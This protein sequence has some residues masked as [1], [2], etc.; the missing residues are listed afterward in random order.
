MV[1]KAR[2]FTFCSNGFL[3]FAGIFAEP[4]SWKGKAGCV[5][6]RSPSNYNANMI[7]IFIDPNP[8]RPAVPASSSLKP[9]VV[10][11]N[12]WCDFAREC[13]WEPALLM[14]LQAENHAAFMWPTINAIAAESLPGDR[15]ALR[16]A[17]KQVLAALGRLI[18]ARRI[19]R[20]RRDGVIRLMV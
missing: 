14:F 5:P 9:P 2:R 19:K 16:A 1:F 11:A 10:P 15:W 13:D 8:P 6:K 18:R 12:D 20:S 17:K 7:S 3:T 4:P